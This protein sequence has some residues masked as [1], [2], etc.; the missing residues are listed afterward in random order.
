MRL[1][2]VTARLLDL[3]LAALAL[4][5]RYVERGI[6]LILNTDGRPMEGAGSTRWR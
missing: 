3:T 6:P 1:G 2:R 4:S 5:R